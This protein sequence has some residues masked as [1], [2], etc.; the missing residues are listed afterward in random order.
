MS[1]ENVV[2]VNIYLIATFAFFFFFKLTC[3]F[4][5]KIYFENETLSVFFCCF[6]FLVL[7][8]FNKA[9]LVWHPEILSFEV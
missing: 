6:F 1:H 8:V 2:D 3:T 4:L 5:L 7:A 9:C